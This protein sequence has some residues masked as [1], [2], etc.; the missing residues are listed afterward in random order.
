[1]LMVPTM[2]TYLSLDRVSVPDAC[3]RRD[4]EA[5]IRQ[6]ITDVLTGCGGSVETARDGEEAVAMLDLRQY[7]LVLS[8]I[9]MPR[10]NGYQIYA[11]VKE[12]KPDCPVI[13]MTGFGYDPHHSIIRANQEGLAAVLFKPFKV[14]QLL[15]EIREALPVS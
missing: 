7:D 3:S 1:M 11:A 4:D 15:S 13:L 12:R 8:D 6:T 10:R 9:R 14:D 2:P 5:A